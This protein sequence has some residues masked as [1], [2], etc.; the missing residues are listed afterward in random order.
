MGERTRGVDADE[1]GEDA[2]LRA[3]I[4][5]PVRSAVI[6]RS[7]LNRADE[8]VRVFLVRDL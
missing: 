5:G 2:E 8:R 6:A 1:R 3:V 7:R 4:R